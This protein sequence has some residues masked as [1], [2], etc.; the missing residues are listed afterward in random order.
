[1]KKI[2]AL[3]GR[4]VKSGFRDWLIMYLAMAP[5]IIALVLRLLMPSASESLLNIVTL[6]SDPLSMQL[7]SYAHVSVVTTMEALEERVLRMDDVIG[8]LSQGEHVTMVLQGN[9]LA[10]IE[11]M[12]TALID[13]LMY[14]D[15]ELPVNIHFSNIGW[16]TSPLQLQGGN[17]LFIMTTVFGGMFIVLNLVDEKMYQTLKALNVAPISRKQMV[18]GKGMLGFFLPIIG[19]LGAAWILGFTNLHLGMFVFTIV[20]TA[21]ISIIIGFT[22]GVMNDEPIAAVASMK[23]IFVPVLASVFGAMFLSDGWHWLLYWSPFYWA[24]D[25]INAILLQQATWGQLLRNSSIIIV[26]SII[27]FSFLRKRIVEGFQ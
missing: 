7:N 22:I 5:F 15:A 24:Y 21:L 13:R 26:I 3:V 8:I 11:P 19:S 12:A 9:E 16:E 23:V 1:M 2:L 4:D 6:E 14:P 20:S 18:I 27:V 25:S 10:H 17:L